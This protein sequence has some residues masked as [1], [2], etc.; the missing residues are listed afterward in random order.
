M[1]THIDVF[2]HSIEDKSGESTGHVRIFKTTRGDQTRK[3]STREECYAKS[4]C[5]ERQNTKVHPCNKL[6]DHVS[7][8][9][10]AFLSIDQEKQYD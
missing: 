4:S 3:N 10:D 8:P 9:I 5:Q 2:S 6:H 1:M 7:P